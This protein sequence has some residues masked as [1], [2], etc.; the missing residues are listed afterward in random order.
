[1]THNIIDSA[2]NMF[3]TA[4]KGFGAGEK[5][6]SFLYNERRYIFGACGGAALYRR[7][8]IDEIGFLDED[9]FLI[10]ED[11]D[12]DFRAQLSGW[13][14]LYVP[15]AIVYHRV[16]SSIGHMS[17]MAV[18]YTLRNS[19]LVRIKNTPI[20]VFIKCLP[21]FFIGVIIEFIYFAIKHKNMALYLKA[22]R[23]A[24]RLLPK[25]LKKRTMIM[26]NK[27]VSNRYILSVMT[28]V[29][30]KDFLITKIKKFL[31]A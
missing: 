19:E 16:R 3:S 24:I 25:M 27:K 1:M 13:K 12:L 11:I 18:Y 30:Q 5:Q 4:L 7:K 2:G 23:D 26:K 31:Y 21:E 9:F 20:G 15:T 10:Q 22:K 8:M 28:P 29:W 6:K 17:N 14:A